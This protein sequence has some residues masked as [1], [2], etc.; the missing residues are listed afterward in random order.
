M[1]KAL[2][3]PQCSA[4]LKPHPF[5]RTITCSYC[6]AVVR[7][8]GS[9]VSA[10]R[11]HQAY[12]AWNAPQGGETVSLGE[13]HW[14]LDSLLAHG[15][16][17]D[18]YAGRRAR[19]PTELVLLKIA[20]DEHGRARLENEWKALE[21]LN[22]RSPE[23]AQ[24]FTA[25]IPQPVL[26]GAMDGGAFSGR[27]LSVFRRAGG[28]KHT[29]TA[30]R[31]AYPQGIEPRA[32]IWVWRR[33]LEILA[34]LHQAG[35]AH[36]GLTPE[37]LLVQ[38]GEHGVRLVGFGSA[39]DLES[40]WAGLPAEA[41]DFAPQPAKNWQRLSPALDIVMSARC[42]AALLGGR[43]DGSGLPGQ[44][45]PALARLVAETA[46][47]PAPAGMDAWNLRTRLG[48]L[49]GTLYG[50]PQFIPIRMPDD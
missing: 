46:A 39:G 18:V 41:A 36:G 48:E 23:A 22:A 32:S 43:P 42:V 19:W 25:Q 16:G 10:E 3:C 12:Q 20:R 21:Q 9:T 17:A 47:A 15:A 33:M 2:L 29:F 4:P 30:V 50:A 24:K 31:Q 7:L 40:P 6:G 11:F 27:W 28:F 13:R 49:A 38:T 26:H 34:L 37:N 14:T 44:V 5:A 1:E 35:L 45:P 8:D